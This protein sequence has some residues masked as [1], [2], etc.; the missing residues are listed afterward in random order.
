M[1]TPLYDKHVALGAKIV[2]F[3]DW[4]M[5]LTYEG[6]VAE[7]MAVRDAVGL[8]DVS[9]MGRLIVTGTDA[10]KFLNFLSTNKIADRPDHSAT[11]TVWANKEGGSVD[12]TIV[13]REG[14]NRFF[15][16][17]N[18][19]NRAKDRQHLLEHAENFNVSVTD[20]YQAEGILAVQG[21]N[22]KVVLH[23]VLPG[24]WELK[25]MSFMIADFQGHEITVSRTGY[26]GEH[27]YELFA[28]HSIL[29]AL[30]DRLMAVGEEYGMQPCG[31]G[32]RDTLRLE[33][34][35][36]LYGHELDDRIAAT[37]SVSAWTVKWKKG[38]F[39][40]Q[41]ALLRLQDSKDKRSQHG[42]CLIDRGVPR[43]GC[44]VYKDGEVIGAVTSGSFSPYL[45]TG[46]A[47]VMVSGDLAIDEKVEVEV[48]SK[49]L[50]GRVVKLPFVKR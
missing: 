37:E 5:P 33:A 1:R 38:P 26:T 34:G 19:G 46:I 32:A 35:Y 42:I 18:A 47:I 36:A 4:E 3:A 30:W 24:S 48:R 44:R 15:V 27:G 50:P 2:P 21:P 8:F 41:G 43:E 31:L 14:V 45:K 39:L 22:S 28:P 10:E 11:Y 25:P 17:A 20:R 12:D 29:P 23:E 13:F 49:R 40:G 7:H 6:V 9:H 16:V